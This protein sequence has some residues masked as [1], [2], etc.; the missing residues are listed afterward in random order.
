[1]QK[2]S[3]YITLHCPL[4]EKTNELIDA[5]FIS[6]MKTGASLINTARGLVINEKAVAD[7][8]N[9]GKLSYFGADV[10]STEPPKEDN[11]LLSSKN[12]FITPHIAWASIDARKRLME[13]ESGNIKGYITGNLQNVVN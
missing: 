10:L 5:D 4:T 2:N 9:S 12:T 8:L 6:K 3:D 7:A 11:P 1:V 13:I